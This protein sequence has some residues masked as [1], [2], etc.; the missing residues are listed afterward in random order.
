MNVTI[1]NLPDSVGASLK[2][3]AAERG[4]SL[5]AYLIELLTEAK[6]EPAM[7]RNVQAAVAE[8]KAVLGVM[9]RVN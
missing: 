9:Q 7:R 6:A 3:A 2:Q 4:Q 8:L 5:N 1:K